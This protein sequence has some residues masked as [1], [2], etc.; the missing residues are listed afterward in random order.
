MYVNLPRIAFSGAARRI[1]W[2]AV[3]DE[4]PAQVYFEGLPEKDRA[5]AEA[6]FRKMAAAGRITNKLQ[7]N[8]EGEDIWCF[9]PGGHRFACFFDRLDCLVTHGFKKQHQK[10]PRNELR[11]ALSVRKIYLEAK[12][13]RDQT[14]KG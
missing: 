7:F 14:R 11:R 9:K 12:A 4:Y 5:R 13:K 2:A 8:N 10:M 6:L 3:S 1:L